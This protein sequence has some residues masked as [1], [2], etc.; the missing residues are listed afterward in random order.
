MFS[1]ELL[2]E[3]ALDPALIHLN[4]AAM[5]PWPRRTVA[6]VTAFASDNAANA[7][8]GYARWLAVEHR[9]RAA[10]A[11]LLN[12]PAAEDIAL[13]G[14]TSSA[15]SMVAYGLTWRA[16][17]NVVISDEE[18][19][20]NRVVWESLDKYAVQV[21]RANLWRSGDP[22]Q[23][24][25]D[26]TDA[27]TRV[28]AVSSV[29]FRSGLRLDLGR[30]GNH[31][32]RHGV[33]FCV[34]GIQSLG[35]VPCDVQAEAIDFIMADGHKWLLGAEGLALFYCRAELRDQLDLKQ[36]GWH[37][38][39][40]FLNFDQT[41]WRP[42][43]GAQRFEPGSPNML[44]IHALDASLGLLM[45]A[46]IARIEQAILDKTDYLAEGLLA[47]GNYEIITP[48]E[49][50]RRAGILTL[51]HR[52]G[53]NAELHR[54]LQANNVYC[55]LRGGNLRLSPHFYTP[56]EKLDAFLQLAQTYRPGIYG[57]QQ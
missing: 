46:Q 39:H 10:A 14:S 9:L 16:G 20:S 56:L 53:D 49:R 8:R 35:A 43:V 42:A 47:S 1:S 27:R 41:A 48:R 37:M 15:L 2:Q 12:A 34:D 7:G 40:D 52:G 13:V 26:L 45:E 24:L 3:F 17:D 28:L 57:Q 29:Q 32:R 25:L 6:A 18:F 30:I 19:P 51:S 38:L 36:Y 5:A 50:R 4:H 31:C 11:R 55:A 54:F 23:A 33:L 22:E 21:R 44:G